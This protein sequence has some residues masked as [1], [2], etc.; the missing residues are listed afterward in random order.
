MAEQIETSDKDEGARE[1]RGKLMGRLAMAGVLVAL[2][3]GVLAFFDHLSTE[4]D[5][6]EEEVFTKP[7]PVAPRKEI[8][9]PVTSVEKPLDASPPASAQ[10][11]VLPATEMPQPPIVEA[12]PAVPSETRPSL[13]VP[14]NRAAPQTPHPPES[15]SKP[16]PEA[17][18]APNNVLAL[19]EAVPGAEVAAPR[20]SARPV[21]SRPAPPSPPRLFSGFLLQA[22]VFS[23]T[24]RAEELHARLT[25]SGI[26]SVMETR[27]QVGPFKTRQEAE[28][29]QAKLKALGVDSLV[30]PPKGKN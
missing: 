8:S 27:V 21:E 19:P 13:P 9:Q 1:L 22:G 3:L 24:Q 23:S 10:A 25:L 17:T 14:A 7:V 2:L 28:A 4:P 30:V 16:V 29:A 26:P 5:M 15:S 20:P 11:E 6:E 12:V 18:T